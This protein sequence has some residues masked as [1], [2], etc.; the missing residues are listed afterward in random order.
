MSK[1]RAEVVI[2][3]LQEVITRNN[4]PSNIQEQIESIE[5]ILI[6]VSEGLDN[7]IIPPY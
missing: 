3:S 1:E 4:N 5:N 6:H 2:T 7:N